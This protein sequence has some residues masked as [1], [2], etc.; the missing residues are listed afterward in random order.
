MYVKS[1]LSIVLPFRW[2]S[3]F[4]IFALC[5]PSGA[6]IA[7]GGGDGGGGGALALTGAAS[8]FSAPADG[9]TGVETE[10][11]R[12]WSAPASLPFRSP[13]DRV[14]M[15]TRLSAATRRHGLGGKRALA[16]FLPS[17]RE[18]VR[19]TRLLCSVGG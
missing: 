11:G 14:S 19:Y 12:A 16:A 10:S 18:R 6:V 1:Q 9:S 4:F 17:G 2:S 3:P 5:S 15:T 8:G 13:N 7:S